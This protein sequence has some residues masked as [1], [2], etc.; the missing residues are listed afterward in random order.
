[1][2]D[3]MHHLQKEFQE[4]LFRNIISSMKKN[5]LLIYKDISNRNKFSARVAGINGF[6]NFSKETL[7]ALDNNFKL[8]L[9]SILKFIN[10][11]KNKKIIIFGFTYL[12]Y[13][14]FLKSLINHKKK[15]KS[16]K[17]YNDTWWWMEKI[18]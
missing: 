14:K 5:S 4:I 6:K 1:M 2:I 15:N 10:K 12:I 3:V 16:L 7:F 9:K 17:K 11:H 18:V 13:E 8:D